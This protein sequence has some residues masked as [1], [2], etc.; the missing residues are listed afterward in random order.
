MA[1][2][3]RLISILVLLPAIVPSQQQTPHPSERLRPPDVDVSWDD[4][5]HSLQEHV[6][7]HGRLRLASLKYKDSSLYVWLMEQRKRWRTGDLQHGQSMRLWRLGAL[8]PMRAVWE[9]NFSLVMLCKQH[10][11]CVSSGSKRGESLAVSNELRKNNVHRWVE[12]QQAYAAKGSLTPKRKE[13]LESLGIVFER[14]KS[15]WEQKYNSL[16]LFKQTFGHL[17]LLRR[18]ESTTW[19]KQERQSLC[20]WLYNQKFQLKRDTSKAHAERLLAMGVVLRNRG[21]VWNKRFNHLASFK[22]ANG[23]VK[24]PVICKENP[25]L[26][27]WVINQ[28]QRIRQGRMPEERMKQLETLGFARKA[29]TAGGR[30]KKEAASVQC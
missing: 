3:A 15:E 5:Y 25:T 12:K 7:T 6:D 1:F 20:R 26:G 27:Q 2:S 21:R 19:K 14:F 10:M 30:S 23:H 17:D 8:E 13:M 28:K 18:E 16:C 24:V 4:H 22:K 29:S 9:T 11:G